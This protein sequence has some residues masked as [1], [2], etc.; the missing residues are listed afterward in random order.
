MLA[1]GPSGEPPGCC[2]CRTGSGESSAGR[3]EGASRGLL[4]TDPARLPLRP[5]RRSETVGCLCSRAVTGSPASGPPPTDL[6]GVPGSS[7]SAAAATAAAAALRLMRLMPSVN[8]HSVAA[9]MSKAVYAMPICSHCGPAA[10]GRGR[11]LAVR[12][13]H[14]TAAA[15]Q[16]VA[17]GSGREGMPVSS[18]RDADNSKSRPEV[19]RGSWAHPK[20]D[21]T[22]PA[23]RGT[24]CSQIRVAGCPRCLREA[25]RWTVYLSASR[26]PAAGQSGALRWEPCMQPHRTCESSAPRLHSSSRSAV[27]SPNAM[28]TRA[29][30]RKSGGVRSR[31]ATSRP[32]PSPMTML[33]RRGV[34]VERC[35]GGA[36]GSRSTLRQVVASPWLYLTAWPYQQ[37]LQPPLESRSPDRHVCQQGPQVADRAQADCLGELGES[38]GRRVHHETHAGHNLAAACIQHPLRQTGGLRTSS[39]EEAAGG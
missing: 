11:L 10:A 20:C 22:R 37:L 26:Q 23:C 7:P 5:L 2:C 4:L 36:A 6:P 35:V 39:C 3:G 33:R 32:R 16:R 13:T 14:P 28:A 27:R 30:V 8:C 15:S 12:G 21:R 31:R 18:Q 38:E 34:H 1:P 19:A 9:A 29:C 17:S 25:G 24:A